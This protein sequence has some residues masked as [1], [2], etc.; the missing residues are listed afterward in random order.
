MKNTINP[1]ADSEYQNLRRLWATVLVQVFKDLDSEILEQK[2]NIAKWILSHPKDFEEVC[3]LANFNPTFIKQH[4]DQKINLK[5]YASLDP[6]DT[7]KITHYKLDLVDKKKQVTFL[8]KNIEFTCFLEDKKP[9]FDLTSLNVQFNLFSTHKTISNSDAIVRLFYL[10]NSVDR[11]NLKKIMRRNTIYIFIN[12]D[13]LSQLN[14]KL[15]NKKLHTFINFI[16]NHQFKNSI[17]DYINFLNLHFNQKRITSIYLKNK[18]F[19]KLVTIIKIASLHYYTINH[20]I[21][22]NTNLKLI[23]GSRR[24]Q[25]FISADNAIKILNACISPIKRIY[26]IRTQLAYWIAKQTQQIEKGPL[27]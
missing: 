1:I 3:D 26:D 9:Y 18:L 8:Y 24:L 17:L 19:F 14:M 7:K 2:I 10:N 23:C 11:N 5:K 20:L 22:P 25:A 21:D 16:Q 12:T 27:A 6:K 13:G 4:I 15:K